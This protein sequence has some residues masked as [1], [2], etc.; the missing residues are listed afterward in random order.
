VYSSRRTPAMFFK[1]V[2]SRWVGKSVSLSSSPFFSHYFLGVKRQRGY[3]CD[4]GELYI[5]CPTSSILLRLWLWV[6]GNVD[7]VLSRLLVLGSATCV[8]ISGNTSQ[9]STIRRVSGQQCGKGQQPR[10]FFQ[11]DRPSSRVCKAYVCTQTS[12]FRCVTRECSSRQAGLG[13]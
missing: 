1:T 3:G 9:D 13:E 4:G 2:P 6:L 5:F 7:A 10:S 11:D 8:K 12:L